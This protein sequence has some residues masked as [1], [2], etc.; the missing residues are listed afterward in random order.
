MKNGIHQKVLTK[1]ERRAF[2]LVEM[3]VAFSVMAVLMS[4]LLSAVPPVTSTWVE[5]GRRIETYQQARGALEMM[6]RELTPALVDTRMQF[7]VLPEKVL[8]DAGAKNVAPGSMAIVWMAPL[9]QSGEL[10]C[11]GYYLF[12]DP[13][14]GFYRLKRIYIQPD[15]PGEYFPRMVNL[16]DAR[17]PS[18][19][20]DPVSASW[21]TGNWDEKTF[22]EEDPQNDEVV[23]STAADGVVAYWVQCFDLLGNPIPWLSKVSNH[24]GSALIYNSSAYFQMA[25]TVP[26][27]SGAST[28]FLQKTPQVMKANRL[29]AEMEI[30]L[31]TV[32]GEAFARELEIP[33][34]ESVFTNDALDMDASVQLFLTGLEENG[35][36]GAEVFSTR[37]KLV[38]GT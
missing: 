32:D 5:S 6:T 36:K 18:M 38:N 20:T 26:F 14:R 27:D 30:T 34:I 8:T 22:D 12:R 28:E 4:I 23:V 25:T 17:D 33:E 37:V 2:S 7:V 21:F 3:L 15:D 29:P 9:G 31:V 19:R 10:R 24:P 13:E 11:V 35:I 1:F 16:K